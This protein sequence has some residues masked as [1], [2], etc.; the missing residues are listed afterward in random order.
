LTKHAYNDCLLLVDFVITIAGT[1][2][3]QFISSGKPAIIIPGKGPQ[4][5][6]RFAEASSLYLGYFVILV[7]RSENVCN[8]PDKLHLIFQ[9]EVQR[10]G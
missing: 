3:E 8:R 9:N 7:Q 4:F 1:A 2:T 10:M 6:F 5:N